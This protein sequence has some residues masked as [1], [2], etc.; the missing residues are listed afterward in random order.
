MI[1]PRRASRAGAPRSPVELIGETTDSVI[2]YLIANHMSPFWAGLTVGPPAA[3]LSTV[4]SPCSTPRP[5]A[6]AGP[7]PLARDS[8]RTVRSSFSALSWGA[9]SRWDSLRFFACARGHRR[10][11]Q[12]HRLRGTRDG[13]PLSARREPLLAP[14]DGPRRA[15]RRR[16]GTRRLPLGVLMNFHPSARMST[17]EIRFPA[18]SS[19]SGRFSRRSSRKS[20]SR[21][22]SGLLRRS[23]ER[24]ASEISLSISLPFGRRTSFG[25]LFPFLKK[26]SLRT[27][28]P[29]RPENAE[30]RLFSH[31]FR[32]AEHHVLESAC[33]GP[34]PQSVTVRRKRAYAK[35]ALRY[36]M[37]EWCGT[38][39]QGDHSPQRR[40]RALPLC[41]LS[42]KE[43]P[44]N[45]RP[46]NFSPAPWPRFL[47]P[48]S[49][50][51][52]PRVRR[53]TITSR[54]TSA[55]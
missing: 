11:D 2:P 34:Y 28:L 18:C 16:R 55:K 32:K 15:R 24:P 52:V 20:V 53:S 27:A 46:P 26:S 5:R 12:P 19:S 25:G 7:A 39:V 31:H 3:T 44:M 45:F 50:S 36:R 42:R 23:A 49:P 33:T 8:S 38:P 48:R 51:A 9:T 4:S 1:F 10:L 6:R 47:S 21:S 35:P 41:H 29:P 30:I 54:V 13:L 43:N 22:F 37:C 17:V 14:R 40:R